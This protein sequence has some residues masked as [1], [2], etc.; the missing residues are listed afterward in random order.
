[1]ETDYM[2]DTEI[3]DWLADRCYYPNDHPSDR[4]CVLVPESVAAT[5]SFT[6]DRENDRNALRDA[7]IHSKRI[8]GT[9]KTLIELES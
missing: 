5:G 2:S 4:I 9:E 7:V 8:S 3:L 1:M 6:L